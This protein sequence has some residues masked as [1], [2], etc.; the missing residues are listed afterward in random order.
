MVAG[1]S[2]SNFAEFLQFHG[3]LLD[4]NVDYEEFDVLSVAQMSKDDLKMN[5]HFNDDLTGKIHQVLSEQRNEMN[6]SK[7]SIRRLKNLLKNQ[8][9]KENSSEF[10]EFFDNVD[11]SVLRVEDPDV[12]TMDVVS[13][14]NCSSLQVFED[15]VKE[16]SKNME[17]SK[18][19]VMNQAGKD[20]WTALMIAS[21][22]GNV[23]LVN[24]LLENDVNVKTKNNLG[25]TALMIAASR[26]YFSVIK[27]IGEHGK[28]KSKLFKNGF[29][30]QMM[31]KEILLNCADHQGWTA[32]HHAVEYNRVD[33]VKF[34][35]EFGADPNVP[36]KDGM[37]PTLIACQNTNKLAET[38]K[39]GMTPTLMACQNTNKLAET[40]CLRELIKAGGKVNVQNKDGKNGLDLTSYQNR[41][42]EAI[43]SF[44][45]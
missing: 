37:T 23:E 20:D 17:I 40:S 32:L 6:N 8:N 5:F 14:A 41:I 26:G 2:V 29:S 30:K 22:A 13:A 7:I 36:D 27:L 18:K 25:Q 24:H 35:L 34:L 10:E 39:D 11:V 31:K 12:I 43:N 21:M 38:N 1:S 16:E 9:G 28:N 3:F 19:E 45:N 33:S 42:L 4:D 44:A 15:I